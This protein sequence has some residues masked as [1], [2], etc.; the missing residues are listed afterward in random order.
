M[1]QSLDDKLELANGV[2]MPSLTFGTWQMP[3]NAELAS[4]VSTA[5]QLGYRSFDTARNYGNAHLI[6]QGIA[7]AGLAREDCFLTTKVWIHNR[8]YEGVFETLEQALENFKTTYI[9]LLLIHWPA[10]QG[11]PM[12]W[13]SLNTGTWR[14]MEELYNQGRV[15]AIGVSNF[16]PHHLVPLMARASIKPMVNQLEL[17]PGYP[18]FSAVNYCFDNDIALQAWSPLGRGIVLRH[19]TLLGLAEKYH[20]SAA[21]IALRWSLQHGFLPIVRAVTMAHLKE[22]TQLFD[23]KLSETDMQLID[24]MPQTAFSGLHPD[25]VVL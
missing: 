7:N 18:Q 4:A 3:D 8:T 10:T 13:Q 19:P 24:N 16:L 22:N 17:H 25:S 14:A 20:V 5:I 1:F 2:Q 11:E 15:R 21:Q 23:F 9:D 6:A 12:I